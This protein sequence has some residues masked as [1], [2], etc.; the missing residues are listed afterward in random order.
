[1]G[2]V[3]KGRMLGGVGWSLEKV[4]KFLKRDVYVISCGAVPKNDDPFGRIIHNYSHPDKVS[5]S[6]NSALTNTSVKYNTFKERVWLVCLRWI[7]LSK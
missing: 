5:G 1:M 3:R 7:G 6:I 4:K 2:E